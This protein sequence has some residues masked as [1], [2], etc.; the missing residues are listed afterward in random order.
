MRFARI[1]YAV[2][3]I[4]GI[5]LLAPQYFNEARVGRDYPP[6]ITHPE[7]YYGFLAAALAWQV[8]FLIISRDPVRNRTAMLASII[9]KGGYGLAVPV[10]YAQQRVAPIFLATGIV[11]LVLGVL[12]ACA[13]VATRPAR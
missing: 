11:D 1:V 10:L 13:Y 7:F 6:A 2:A 5:V 9:E 3:G 12:F 8:L 4:Y